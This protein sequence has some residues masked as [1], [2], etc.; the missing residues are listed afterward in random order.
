M[1]SEKE[2]IDLL[3][4]AGTAHNAFVEQINQRFHGVTCWL[5][6]ITAALEANGIVSGAELLKA[7]NMVGPQIDQIWARLREETKN[8][9]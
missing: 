4:E 5:T 3:E 1:P 2:L 9:Q 7:T 8:A 6:A